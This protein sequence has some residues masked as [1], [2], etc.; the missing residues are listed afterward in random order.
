MRFGERIVLFIFRPIYRTFVE[1]LL[2][3]FLTKVKIFFLADIAVQLDSIERR[4]REDH[5]QRW[6]VIE[7][8]L[9]GAEV[10]NTAQWDAMEQLLLA[11]FREP[12][13]PRLDSDWKFNSAQCTAISSPAELNR[14][15]AAS[16]LR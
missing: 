15:H 12:E 9:R 6:A 3:W 16:N 1:R 13:L 4:L 5:Q 14:A 7:E 8:R 10:S 11:L 2:W